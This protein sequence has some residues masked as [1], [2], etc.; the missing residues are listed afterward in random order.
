[1]VI[2]KSDSIQRT[3]AINH[4]TEK[5]KLPKAIIL[6]VFSVIFVLP[7]I[8]LVCVFELSGFIHFA[9]LL[10]KFSVLGVVIIVFYPLILAF[11][12][13]YRLKKSREAILFDSSPERLEQIN[14]IA[15]RLPFYMFLLDVVYALIVPNVLL[16]NFY[17][18]KTYP[19]GS[20]DIIFAHLLSLSLFIGTYWLMRPFASS[21]LQNAFSSTG[22]EQITSSNEAKQSFYLFFIKSDFD[23][24]SAILV[25]IFFFAFTGAKFN[26]QNINKQKIA[27][28]EKVDF[29]AEKLKPEINSLQISIEEKKANNKVHSSS[30]N[31]T[32]PQK[33]SSAT[34]SKISE[35]CKQKKLNMLFVFAGKT[36]VFKFPN[37]LDN[38][39]IENIRKLLAKHPQ[40]KAFKLSLQ[41]N[42]NASAKTSVATSKKLENNG[43]IIAFQNYESDFSFL[44]I[45]GVFSLI[46]ALFFALT[47]VFIEKPTANKA[48][49][50]IVKI[51]DQI[52][53]GKTQIEPI[54]FHSAFS[55]LGIISGKLNKA[56]ASQ[57]SILNVIK[58]ISAG[59]FIDDDSLQGEIGE[60]MRNLF[61]NQRGMMKNIAD[62]ISQ[63]SSSAEQ[64]ASA[65]DE[66][67]KTTMNQVANLEEVR[68]SVSNLANSSKGIADY[69]K[70]VYSDAAKTTNNIE[71]LM[72]KLSEL[73]RHNQRIVDFLE[74][75]KEIS[76]RSD[77]LALNASLEASRAGEAGKSFMLVASEMRRLAELVLDAVE[78]IKQLVLDIRTSSQASVLATEE[79]QKL[80]HQMNASASEITNLTDMQNEG[81]KQVEITLE[82][83]A[84]ALQETSTAIEELS[85][86]SK[87]LLQ[88]AEKLK[89]MLDI[90]KY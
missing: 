90:Y 4:Y 23:I 42:E 79:E 27:L 32:N 35:L 9:D 85:T 13:F 45:S 20:A 46:F 88:L 52:S 16:I 3:E 49:K 75:V 89:D 82:E 48:L 41:V 11:F 63:L 76:D 15:Y 33:F 86:A 83:S 39:K 77:I 71:V 2:Y 72:Q 29:V 59:N 68:A 10:A 1:M 53:L 57:N 62:V 40:Q 19:F 66:L 43:Q 65:S 36:L 5:N 14:L 8:L 87:N 70:K 12:L 50:D 18:D 21:A 55:E 38:E 78:G 60:V 73:V 17:L 64:F 61:K 30:A 81:T 22:F 37:K 44:I 26:A 6:S 56:I 51:I 84:H 54:K 34:A 24:F 58:R 28:E 69:A 67:S 31:Q 7:I 80:A 74:T 25:L 47:I